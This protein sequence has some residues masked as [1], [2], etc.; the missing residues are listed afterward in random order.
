MLTN[1]NAPIFFCLL[2]ITA[3]ISWLNMLNNA[4]L[5]EW[6]LRWPTEP[7]ST[8]YQWST[9]SDTDMS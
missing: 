4:K 9:I 3:L 1:K 2:P 7:E 8:S 5:H 6:N